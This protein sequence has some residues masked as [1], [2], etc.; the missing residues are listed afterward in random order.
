MDS[1]S[2]RNAIARALQGED[3]GPDKIRKV[4]GEKRDLERVRLEG[5]VKGEVMVFQPMTIL[6]ISTAGAMIETTFALQLDS[7]HDFRFSLADRSVIVKGRIA[8]CHIGKLTD[9]A[10][11]Y[12]I[13]VEFVDL[14]ERV[15]GAIGDFVRATQYARS[16]PRVVDGVMAPEDESTL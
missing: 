8:Y 1:A 5:D 6:D 15:H 16:T 9:V 13:G 2:R 3:L 7:L 12:R 14:P 10:A 11:L 4:A